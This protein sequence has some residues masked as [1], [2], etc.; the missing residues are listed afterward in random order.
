MGDGGY[1]L[2]EM[3]VSELFE[4]GEIEICGW[5]RTGNALV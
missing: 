3:D 5:H 4:F 2:S 1:G